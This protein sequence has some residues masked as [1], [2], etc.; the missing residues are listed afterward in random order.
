[1]PQAF[2][3]SIIIR[4]AA[5]TS[6]ASA[7]RM[8]SKS[9]IARGG[10]VFKEATS[11]PV[12]ILMATGS[13]VALA[14]QSADELERLGIPTRVVSIPCF[15]WFNEQTQSYKD[16]ILPPSIKARVSIEAGIA[17]G[18]REYVGDQGACV[19]LEHY[20][21]SAGANTLF[22]EFGFTVENVVATAK[23]IL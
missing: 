19:S 8:T 9:G 1:M 11:T 7:G 3:R 10:Y 4:H 15:E 12:L 18:W 13:E 16:Q 17:Q 21:A 20:G 23:K 5:A 6:F 22:K 2:L 14:V